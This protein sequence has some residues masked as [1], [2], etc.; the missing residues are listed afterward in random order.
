[1]L[2]HAGSLLRLHESG[3]LASTDQ[4]SSVSGGS[5]TA[6]ALAVAWPQLA[7]AAGE[8]EGFID[9]VVGPLQR[10][11]DTTIDRS[12]I[13]K[14]LLLPGSVSEKVAAA[15][16]RH[17]LGRRTLADLPA[18]PHFVFCA[19]NVQTGSLVRF[20]RRGVRDWRV[21][22]FAAPGLRLAQAVAASSA[23]PPVLSPLELDMRSFPITA[24]PG[25]IALADDYR[26]RLILTDGG[27]YDNLGLET[28][29]KRR[30]TLL[31]SD[32]GGKMEDQAR[33]AGDWARHARRVLDIVDNQVRSLR[34]RELIGSFEAKEKAG[35]YW[36][37]R[38]DIA[39]F[40]GSP[41]GCPHAATLALADT[42]TRLAAMPPLL[43][44]RLINWGYAVCAAALAKHYPLAGDPVPEFPFPHAGVG[45]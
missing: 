32:A 23:F 29:W 27:V 44:Q 40:G 13:L 24:E 42:P 2:F 4:I 43:Q 8:R 41:L 1:M 11:A 21:G 45:S 3:L 25:N 12:A 6:A 18:A 34:K 38:S 15:Y 31:V 7:L 9:L 17:L 28:I 39:N 35:A 5:I 30:S 26:A 20:S 33:P 36:G 19:T 37:I 16:D 22:F 10:L 14:G